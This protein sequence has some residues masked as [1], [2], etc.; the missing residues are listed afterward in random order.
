MSHK[1][2]KRGSHKKAHKA[3]SRFTVAIHKVSKPL[4]PADNLAGIHIVRL[5]EQFLSIK[6]IPHYWPSRALVVS[7]NERRNTG[8]DSLY[9]AKIAHFTE[10]AILGLLAARAFRTSPRPAI[11]G[12][13]F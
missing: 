1:V 2:R 12:A 10:Y 7:P 9:Y 4:P 11:A 5:L 13:G 3:Q 6:H 8:N